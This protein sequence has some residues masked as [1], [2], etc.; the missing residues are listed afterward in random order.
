MSHNVSI[1][2][3]ILIGHSWTHI[4]TVADRLDLRRGS[5]KDLETSIRRN[6]NMHADIRHMLLDISKYS[7]AFIMRLT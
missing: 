4:A 1:F 2:E 5:G 6:K 7:A 3:E